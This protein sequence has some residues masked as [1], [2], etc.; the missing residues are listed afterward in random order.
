MEEL[1]TSGL[2]HKIDYTQSRTQL[3][4]K[5]KT[6][7]T[8]RKIWALVEHAVKVLLCGCLVLVGDDMAIQAIHPPY[9]WGDHCSVV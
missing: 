9:M 6:W 1:A 2:K 7:D 8:S 4:S 5:T 3:R